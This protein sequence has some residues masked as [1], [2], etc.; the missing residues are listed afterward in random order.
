MKYRKKG[1]AVVVLL[2]IAGLLAMASTVCAQGE[3]P[4]I[5]KEEAKEKLDDSAV[6]FLDARRGSD[7]RASQYKIKGAVKENPGDVDQWAEKY[8]A[9]KTYIVYCA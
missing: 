4:R 7:W 6:I 1:T 3:I 5:S 2:C 8:D 9:G